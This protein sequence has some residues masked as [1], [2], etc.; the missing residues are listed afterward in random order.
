MRPKAKS[1]FGGRSA[2]RQVDVWT[3]DLPDGK[4]EGLNVKLRSD[5]DGFFFAVEPVGEVFAGIS[6]RN[7]NI[8]D[9]RREVTDLVHRR[10]DEIWSCDWQPALMLTFGYNS[11]TR[12][13]DYALGS[14]TNLDFSLAFRA[15][16]QNISRP[17]GNM[18]EVEVMDGDRKA[19]VLLRSHRDRYPASEFRGNIARM[20]SKD[21]MV[22][23]EDTRT[24]SR[25]LVPRDEAQM[26]RA[27]LLRE[28]LGRFAALL[29]DRLSPSTPGGASIPS[30]ED[31]VDLMRCAADPRVEVEEEVRD[32]LRL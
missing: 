11:R 15:V 32:G 18:G 9:L 2:G 20:S 10:I 1:D 4:R 30:P 25:I 7:A 12:P 16:S 17:V 3:Y 22:Q 27:K 13:Q 21:F 5:E 23:M 6:A 24:D 19:T 31:L 26:D 29:G 28:T 8:Q 14:E